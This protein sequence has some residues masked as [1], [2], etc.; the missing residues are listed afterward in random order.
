M[1]LLHVSKF[2]LTLALQVSL[3][4]ASGQWGVGSK[5]LAVEN[6]LENFFFIFKSFCPK[7]KHLWL[8]NPHFWRIW[9]KIKILSTYDFLCWNFAAVLRNSVR[10]LQYLS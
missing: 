2:G 3:P 8:E 4:V 1:C 5:F 6:L 7:I 10:N 9:W